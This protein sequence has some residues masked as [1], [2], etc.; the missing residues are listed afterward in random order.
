MRLFARHCA[1]NLCR[2]GVFTPMARC[3]ELLQPMEPHVLNAI[4]E[5]FHA[6]WPELC[7]STPTGDPER[8]R[9]KLLGAIANLAQCGIRDP[10]ELKGRALRSMRA[11]AARESR[12][13]RRTTWSAAGA[14]TAQPS[15]ES[16]QPDPSR[17]EL[18]VLQEPT[19]RAMNGHQKLVLRFACSA[20]AG[21]ACVHAAPSLN[22]KG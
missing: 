14:N 10:L 21:C 9:N 19:R 16:I 13:R 12:V 5:G 6:A 4:H 3:D 18:R 2:T 7:A 15:S 22:L 20:E 11:T 1:S 17:G 8:T